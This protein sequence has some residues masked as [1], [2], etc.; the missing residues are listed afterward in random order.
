MEWLDALAE[1]W[2]NPDLVE[3]K[4]DVIQAVYERIA[5]EGRASSDCASHRPP[6]GMDLPSRRQML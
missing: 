6:T 5:I 1:T 4:L 2:L 3:E